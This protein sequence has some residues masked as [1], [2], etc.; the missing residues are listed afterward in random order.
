GMFI[1]EKVESSEKNVNWNGFSCSAAV[2]APAIFAVNSVNTAK[3][4]TEVSFK[5]IEE[6][7]KLVAYPNP[8]ARQT[9]VSFSIPYQ[10]DN[11]VLDIYDLKGT[12]IQSLFKGSANAQTT[13]EVQFNGQNISAGTYFFRLITSKEVKNFKVIMKD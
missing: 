12:K 13:Y 10:E 11:A 4:Q 5:L 7:S 8:F 6:P 2:A 9:T 1:A 3:D